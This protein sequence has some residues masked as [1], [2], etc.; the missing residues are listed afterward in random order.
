MLATLRTPRGG[1]ISAA[2]LSDSS[3]HRL[4]S[5]AIMRPD[6]KIS[7]DTDWIAS[8]PLLGNRNSIVH[9]STESVPFLGSSGGRV[10]ESVGEKIIRSYQALV[11]KRAF[12]AVTRIFPIESGAPRPSNFP[13]VVENLVEFARY[14]I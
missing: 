6:S 3:N 8:A 4:G 5:S 1:I 9:S 10:L 7:F 12:A 11:I 14:V 13:E 2:N